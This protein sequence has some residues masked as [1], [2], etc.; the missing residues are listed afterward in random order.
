MPIEAGAP[1]RRLVSPSAPAELAWLLNLLVQTAPYAEPALSE[2]EESILPGVTGMRD[3]VRRKFRGLWDD[4][5]AGCPELLA[6][7][8]HS[9][10]LLD[11]D[12]A[13]LFQWLARS[14][15]RAAPAYELLSEPAALRGP[16]ATRIDLVCARGALRSRYGELLQEVWQVARGPWEREG[17]RIVEQACGRWRERVE[18]AGQIEDLVA[19]RHP[20]KR[21]DQLGFD[22]LLAGRAS[23]VVSPLYFC[24]SGGHVVDVNEYV[25]IG[26]P[27]SDLL[28]VRK[29][30]DAMF[31]ADR[32]RVLAEPTRVH[33]LIQIMSAPA[34]V[35]EL[36]RALR[37][38]QPTVSGHIK[39]L[40]NAGLIQQRTQ[41]TRSVFVASRKRIE[42]LLEDARGTL[43][44]WD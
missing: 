22:D 41:G 36:A 16:I 38:S 6:A 21:A 19:P 12:P 44:R 43:A 29:V 28:P 8:H 18:G 10:C 37:M 31:V 40:R 34:G 17:R 3:T 5:V 30:R 1:I 42:Q 11:G 4:E 26:V 15:S 2:L 23:L 39:V 9:G 13:R 33:V 24:M 35:M 32:V 7:A 27:A 20:L 25:H 14:T